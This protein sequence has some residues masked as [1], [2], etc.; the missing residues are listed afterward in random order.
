MLIMDV[1][2]VLDE[3]YIGSSKN[4]KHRIS[5]HK[6]AVKR[7]KSKLYRRIRET[8]GGF[9]VIKL[10]DFPCN[11]KKELVEE[12]RRAFNEYKPKL[13]SNRPS[14]TTEEKKEHYS[15][16]NKAYRVKHKD[17]LKLYY[18]ENKDKI[19]ETASAYHVANRDAKLKYQ[20]E[21]D[22]ANRERIREYTKQKITC[23]CGLMYSRNNAR[24]HKRSKKHE[25][26]M[27]NK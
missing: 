18:V 14:I 9:T 15:T 12:E 27:L 5:I 11:N 8:G 4:I 23:E 19:C 6:S 16:L 24:G 22:L 13:N 26:L 20:K 10:Y 25:R 2:D 1:I 7:G 21:Y 17:R 3:I